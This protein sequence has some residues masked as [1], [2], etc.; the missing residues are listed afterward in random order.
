MVSGEINKIDKKNHAIAW[1]ENKFVFWII[2]F[3]Y[4]F[5]IDLVTFRFLF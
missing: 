5:D 3:F 1:F 2:A 4:F